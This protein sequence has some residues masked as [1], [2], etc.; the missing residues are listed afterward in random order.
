MKSWCGGGNIPT[1]SH[2]PVYGFDGRVRQFRAQ[3]T[4]HYH[5]VL[6]GTAGTIIVQ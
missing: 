4:Y 2:D 1:W 6:N 3:G 5:S